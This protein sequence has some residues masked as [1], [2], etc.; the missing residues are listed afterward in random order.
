MPRQNVLVAE[1]QGPRRVNLDAQVDGLDASGGRAAVVG[2]ALELETRT[3]ET[4]LGLEDALIGDGNLERLDGV[5]VKV[6]GLTLGE[7]DDLAPLEALALDVVRVE[8][9][10]IVAVEV[11]QLGIRGDAAVEGDGALDGT[12]STREASSASRGSRREQ[13]EERGGVHLGRVRWG[14]REGV[15]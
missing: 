11:G 2:V 6:S 7:L 10:G 5:V 14:G 15:H 13:A 4:V 8:D 12:G 1:V 3:A 9:R